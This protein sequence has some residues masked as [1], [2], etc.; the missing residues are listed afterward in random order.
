MGRVLG[1]DLKHGPM[2]FC[3][4]CIPLGDRL[5]MEISAYDS[6]K[7]SRIYRLRNKDLHD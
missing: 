3:F 7:G 1:Y 6:T 2:W 4:T 5:K